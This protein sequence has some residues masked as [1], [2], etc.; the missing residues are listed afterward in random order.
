VSPNITGS[1]GASGSTSVSLAGKATRTAIPDQDDYG[2]WSGSIAM[3]VD[4]GL[5]LEAAVGG[6]IDFTILFASGSLAQ[7]EF[8][9]WTIAEGKITCSA[10]VGIPGGLITDSV[11]IKGLELKPPPT[12]APARVEGSPPWGPGSGVSGAG[13]GVAPPEL[14]SEEPPEE[15]QN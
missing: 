14:P 6:S 11:E 4:M 3:P 5:K 9:K 7:W 10:S 12:T 2:D 13:P 15:P 8:G 1:L